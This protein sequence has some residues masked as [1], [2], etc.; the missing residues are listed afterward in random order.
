M[1]RGYVAGCVLYVTGAGVLA[2]ALAL[3]VGAYR[4]GGGLEAALVAALILGWA[5][6]VRWAWGV[7]SAEE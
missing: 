1:L 6:A 2:G 3:I 5:L 7:F 4:N